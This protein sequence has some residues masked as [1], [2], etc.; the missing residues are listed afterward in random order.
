MK[1]PAK[2][3]VRGPLQS[4]EDGDKRIFKCTYSRKRGWHPCPA[5]LAK[6]HL[7]DLILADFCLESVV[8]VSSGVLGTVKKNLQF[9]FEDRRTRKWGMHSYCLV[10]KWTQADGKPCFA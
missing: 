3:V 8:G 4:T 5:L 10:L 2:Q 6:K 1:A 9:L 7:V